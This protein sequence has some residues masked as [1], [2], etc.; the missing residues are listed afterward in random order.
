[1]GVEL[2]VVV[3]NPGWSAGIISSG[4]FGYGLGGG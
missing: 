3:G 1:M 2:G 4:K